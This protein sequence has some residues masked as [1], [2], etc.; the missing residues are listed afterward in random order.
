M[1]VNLDYESGQSYSQFFSNYKMIVSGGGSKRIRLAFKEQRDS[2][3]RLSLSLPKE[4]V[5][6]LAHAMLAAAAGIDQTMECSF[7]EPRP[8]TPAA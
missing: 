4:K 3:A 1:N 8:K 5:A 2:R 7:E 6:Q